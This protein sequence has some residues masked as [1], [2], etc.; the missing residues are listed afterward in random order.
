[1]DPSFSEERSRIQ[2]KIKYVFLCISGVKVQTGEHSSIQ[3]AQAAVRL[4][5][6][7]RTEWE[8]AIREKHK[9]SF[10]GKKKPK[11]ELNNKPSILSSIQ[12]DLSSSGT[13]KYVDSDSD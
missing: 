9:G 7:V 8:S 4:Y 10:H 3:D 2:I 5:T 1:M 13:R 12:K 6:M 11:N